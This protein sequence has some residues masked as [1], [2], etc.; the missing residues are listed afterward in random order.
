MKFHDFYFILSLCTSFMLMIVIFKIRKLLDTLM[1]DH[2]ELQKKHIKL[3]LRL[4]ERSG[5]DTSALSNE[6]DSEDADFK[7]V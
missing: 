7:D 6:W 2:I 5:I 4:L 3:Q 1:D